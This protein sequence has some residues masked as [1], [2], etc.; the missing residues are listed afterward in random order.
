MA[1]PR[2]RSW[3][4]VWELDLGPDVGFEIVNEG[5]VGAFA[6]L[7]ASKDKHLAVGFVDD[8]GVFVSGK[9]NVAARLE[10][11]PRKRLHVETVERR[12][13]FLCIFSVR[14]THLHCLGVVVAPEQEH[15]LFVHARAVIGHR[16]RLRC[17][18]SLLRNQPPANRLT[19]LRVFTVQIRDQSQVQLP[20]RGKTAVLN[21]KTS[22]YI[23][24][25]FK[26]ECAM[27][28]SSLWCIT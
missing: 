13:R 21:V 14:V 19:F 22:I 12:V 8:C 11:R 3:G 26:Y 2:T 15:L 27:I 24:F 4:I 10:L 20:E 1:G 23:H 7:E 5:V 25:V 6:L 18:V 17:L 28:T 16:A 9:H